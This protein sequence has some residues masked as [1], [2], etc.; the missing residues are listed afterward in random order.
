M[1]VTPPQVT[2]DSYI[3]YHPQTNPIP[4]Q[5]ITPEIGSGIQEVFHTPSEILTHEPG[6]PKSV[7][8]MQQ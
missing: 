5:G 2:S 1:E 4:T 6:I 7:L 3:P 8:R